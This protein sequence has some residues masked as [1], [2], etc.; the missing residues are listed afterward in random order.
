MTIKTAVIQTFLKS[1]DLP[2]VPLSDGLR[3]QVLPDIG[4]LSKCQ[5]HHF[6]AF[7]HYPPMLVVWDDDPEHIIARG[8]AIEQQLVGMIWN[9]VGMKDNT[10]YKTAVKSN[11]HSRAPT[12]NTKEVIEDTGF[13]SERLFSD[14]PRS[15]RLFQPILIG[16]AAI[17]AM[18]AIGIGWRKIVIEIGVDHD[19]LRLVFI[20]VVPAQLWLGWVS[21]IVDVLRAELTIAVLLPNAGQWHSPDVRTCQSDCFQLEI[22]LWDPNITTYNRGE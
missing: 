4:Y 2:F 16:V 19:W 13:D 3:L 20:F 21:R 9:S 18:G 14:Q 15:T 17:L 11:F 8:E 5:K 10:D 22:L 12:V 7:V 1:S 6:A